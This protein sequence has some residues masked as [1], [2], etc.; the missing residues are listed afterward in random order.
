MSLALF[1]ICLISGMY[2]SEAGGGQCK[3]SERSFPGKALKGHTFKEFAVRAI[4][5]CQNTCERDPRC[6]SYNFYIPG[7]VC[8]L[9][10]HTKEEKPHHFVTDDQRFYMKREVIN[11]QN[12]VHQTLSQLNV[13]DLK[14]VKST[15]F[16]RVLVNSSIF[17][18]SLSS[19][20][21]Q[22]WVQHW[23]KLREVLRAVLVPKRN[24]EWYTC[25]QK[26][27]ERNSSLYSADHTWLRNTEM[28]FPYAVWFLSLDEDECLKTPPV[29]DVNANCNNTLGSYL[30]SCKEGFMGDG[31]ACQGKLKWW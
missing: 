5:E 17:L 31:K 14:I 27:I 6:A 7:K 20:Q 30:C 8:E 4:V 28:Y 11:V 21:G 9:N 25:C 3:I 19:C 26:K 23:A 15:L 13:T 2:G 24:E 18:I 22:T 1:T 29:C 10:S 12:F 16:K